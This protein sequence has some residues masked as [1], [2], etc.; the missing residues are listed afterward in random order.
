MGDRGNGE[1]APPVALPL[2]PPADVPPDLARFYT[3]CDAALADL[4]AWGKALADKIG[5]PWG[6]TPAGGVGP[7]E[8]EGG[9]R[10]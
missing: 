7:G 9:G 1:G 2:A 10:G 5:V 6:P 4:D 3:R 8:H